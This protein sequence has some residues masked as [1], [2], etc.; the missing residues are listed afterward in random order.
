MYQIVTYFELDKSW[1]I[2]TQKKRK[3]F[4]FQLLFE[5]RVFLCFGGSYGIEKWILCSSIY[6]RIF[7]QMYQIVT[8]FELDKSWKIATQ[9]KRKLFTFQLLFE[10]RVFSSAARCIKE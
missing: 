1:K 7:T 5:C 6:Y 10:C 3:L 2:A 9:K 4:T 8:Y